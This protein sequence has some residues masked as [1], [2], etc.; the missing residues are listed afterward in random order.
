[1]LHMLAH[2]LHWQYGKVIAEY[3]DDG[4]LWIAFKCTKC[5]KVS[6]AFISIKALGERINE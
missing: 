4:N 1:M 3:D 2:W 6:G 5:G